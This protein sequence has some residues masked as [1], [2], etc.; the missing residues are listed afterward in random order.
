MLFL[1]ESDVKALLPMGDAVG[2][3]RAT[4]EALASGAA[5]NQPRRR[6]VTPAGAV[7]HQLAGTYGN[8][9]GVKV[10]S[11]HVR[12]G[13][14][15]LVL[16]YDGSTGLPLAAIEAN[17]LG[18]IRTGAASGFATD[19]LARPDS[20]VLGVI[21]TGFQARSQ[22]EA[23]CAVRPIN[24][25][26]VYGRNPERRAAFAAECAQAV[27]AEVQ[28]APTSQA[29]VQ[30]ADIVVTA[31]WAKEPV[32]DADWIRPGTH[33]NAV[34]SNQ[35]MRR[36]LP[37]ELLQR[38]GFIVVDSVEQARIEAGDLLLGLR[39]WDKVR[40]LSGFATWPA[41]DSHA[42]TLF[43]SVG[44]GVQDIAAA[45]LVYE[46]AVAQ[47]RGSQTPCFQS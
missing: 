37:G 46:R 29:A 33:I 20:Q 13:A 45:G 17:H 4:F 8:Y 16:L 5:K 7:L 10:Y 6:L 23:I 44:L 36:E 18:Q 24:R 12:H 47:G 34:G 41:R 39:D 30:E 9:Y 3:M 21:G 25:I 42:V 38:A 14:W 22:V 15:F 26:L 1:A 28:A 32:L 27:H 31:T 35:P 11:T 2:L 40:E 19:V 43:K